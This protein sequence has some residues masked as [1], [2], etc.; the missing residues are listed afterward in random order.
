MA[1]AV[2]AR[3]RF[4]AAACVLVLPSVASARPIVAGATAGLAQSKS[5]ASDDASHTLGLFGRV[6]FTPR[7][8]GQLELQQY[9][10][11]EDSST[12]M[13]TWGLLLVVDLA[14]S[15]HWVPVLVAGLGVDHVSS[16]GSDIAHGHHYEGGFGIEYRSDGG[17][18]IGADA[19]MGGRSM[20]DD[21]VFDSPQ[22]G[23]VKPVPGGPVFLVPNHLSD[24]EYRSLRLTLAVRF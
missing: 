10:T 13:R 11:E 22:A 3:M 9:R 24:G 4:V 2:T 21:V 1:R 17:L 20:E 12:Q 18:T 16:Y 15:K 6:G 7:L 8:S 5:D 14:E 23:D 19:R